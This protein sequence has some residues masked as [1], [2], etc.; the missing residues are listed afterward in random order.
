MIN[1]KIK[2][3]SELHK[4][5]FYFYLKIIKSQWF[6]L[7]K[8][9]FIFYIINEK[10]QKSMTININIPVMNG[11]LP[12]K[13]PPGKVTGKKTIITVLVGHDS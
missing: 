2:V 7:S 12:K 5:I 13:V 10:Y 3:A 11:H 9:L 6:D 1:H 8:F 4:K